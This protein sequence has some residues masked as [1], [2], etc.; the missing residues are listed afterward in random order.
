MKEQLQPLGKEPEEEKM[1]HNTNHILFNKMLELK[2]KKNQNEAIRTKSLI[3]LKIQNNSLNLLPSNINIKDIRLIIKQNPRKVFLETRP[4]VIRLSKTIFKIV[5][6]LLLNT[7]WAINPITIHKNTLDILLS[8]SFVN[9]TMEVFRIFIPFN[10]L[11]NLSF[12]R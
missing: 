4:R 2:K 11:L 5:K 1:H 10:G 12:L 3:R 8:S 7:I 9:H 6:K